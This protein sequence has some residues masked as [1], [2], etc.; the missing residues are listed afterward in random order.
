MIEEQGRLKGIFKGFKN[1]GTTFQFYGGGKWKQMEYKYNYQYF[2]MP[3]AKVVYEKGCYMMHV[4][5][6]DEPVEVKKTS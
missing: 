4:D 6:I 3:D 1:R 5:G 2:Y